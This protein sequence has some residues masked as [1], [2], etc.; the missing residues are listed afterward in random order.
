M[1][2]SLATQVVLVVMAVWV[3]C[4]VDVSVQIVLREDGVVSNVFVGVVAFQSHVARAAVM[5]VVL[6]LFEH[7]AVEVSSVVVIVAVA[8]RM[9]LKEIVF[10]A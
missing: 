4:L 9:M 8:V 6:G 10:V 3:C 2:D 7:V 1:H 5:F